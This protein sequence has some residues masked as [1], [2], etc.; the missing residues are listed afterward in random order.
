MADQKPPTCKRCGRKLTAAASIARGRG[1]TCARIVREAAKAKA[2][3][4]YK[5]HQVVKAVELIELH[6][7]VPLRRGVYQVPSSDG[8]ATYLAHR[9][10]CTCPA[11]LKAEHVCKHR[12]AAHLLT[13]AA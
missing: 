1:A 8:T 7:L 6:A 10:G 9:C 12:I 3:A 2:I 13:I 4:Q 5:P 11:G